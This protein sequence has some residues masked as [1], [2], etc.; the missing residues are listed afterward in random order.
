MFFVILTLS[1]LLFVSVSA[2]PTSEL[3]QGS[4]VTLQCQVKGLPPS[5]TVKWKRPDGRDTQSGTVELKSAAPSDQ[6]TWTC[7]IKVGE[8]NVS[9]TLD[10]K[11]K[12]R[13]LTSKQKSCICYFLYH[14]TKHI[15]DQ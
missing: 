14:Y 4:E 2:N 9:E 13:T 12:G 3:E 10:L 1:S 8:E 6:G 5:A 15:C 11:V 7:V